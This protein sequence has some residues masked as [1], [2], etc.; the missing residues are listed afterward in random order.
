MLGNRLSE[1]LLGIIV[2]IAVGFVLSVAKSVIIPMVIAILFS[3]ML[4]PLIIFFERIKIPRIVA[5]ILVLLFLFGFCYLV[6]IIFYSSINAF[7]DQFPW[8]I[9]QFKG[10]YRDFSLK[11]MTQFDISAS[12]FLLDYNWGRISRS[13]ILSVSN[14]LTKL[15]GYIIMVFFFLIFLFLEFPQFRLKLKKAFPRSTSKRFFIVI[16]HITREFGKYL[17]IKVLIS[18]VTGF[19][20]WLALLL[21]GLDFPLVWGSL[22]FFMNF[23]PNIGSTIV[24]FFICIQAIVQFY[25]SAGMVILIAVILT[26]IQMILGNIVEPEMQGSKLNLSP[27]I[28][29]FSLVFWGWLWGAVG[30]ILSV[31]ITVTIKIVCLNIP[32]LR[33]VGVLMGTGSSR[34][35]LKP[36]RKK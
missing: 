12:D 31:P 32:F 33:P 18:V 4:Y 3:F 5:I 2:V 34:R 27:V 35:K 22:T 17:T 6:V 25:P 26:T 24:V 16:G 14:S 29:L 28:I 9:E 15:V 30:A 7:S 20:T 21:M 13:Y 1:V 10:I 8:Y 36:K 11:L 23:I 19:C